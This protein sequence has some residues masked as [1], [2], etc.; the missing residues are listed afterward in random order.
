MTAVGRGI[1]SSDRLIGLSLDRLDVYMLEGH[2]R[3]AGELLWHDGQEWH[4]GLEGQDLAPAPLFLEPSR[5]PGR[6]AFRA[7]VTGGRTADGLELSARIDTLHGSL[8]EQPLG[9]RAVVDFDS[10]G[11][12]IP[13]LDLQWGPTVVHAAGSLA[14]PYSFSFEARTPD[15]GAAIPD[16][17]GSVEL[18]GRLT[19]TTA[20]PVVQVTMDMR[21]IELSTYR[22]ALLTGRLDLDLRSAGRIDLSLRGEQIELAK[23]AFRELRL[24]A[25]GDRTAHRISTYLDAG[26]L[27][28]ALEATG[29]LEGARESDRWRGTIRSLDLVSDPGGAWKLDSAAG[30]AIAP[31]E[32]TLDSLCL[33]S[34][35]SSFCSR[36]TWRREGGWEINSTLT[37]VP[38]VLLGSIFPP[39]WSLDGPLSGTID[40]SAAGDGSLSA[41]IN[42]IPGPGTI[43]YPVG[44]GANTVGYRA[45]TVRLDADAR[46]IR[47]ALSLNLIEQGGPAFGWLSARLELPGYSSLRQSIRPQ[48]VVGQ[49]DA[50]FESLELLA[51]LLTRFARA[52]GQL[53]TDLTIDGT[54]GQ[55][56]VLGEMRLIDAQA[57]VP[58]LGLRIEDVQLTAAGDGAGSI[59]FNGRARSGPGQLRIEGRSPVVP[60][61]ENPARIRIDGTNF[62]VSNT[63]A[64]EVLASP[65]IETVV[66]GE[67]ISVDGD[68]HI[69]RASIVL[70]QIPKSAV[71]VSDDVIFVDAGADLRRQRLISAR[72]RMVL[73]ED[74][75][76]GGFGLSTGLEG[77][78]L[79]TEEPGRP[80][81]GSGE[82]SMVE[83]TYKAYGQ[84]L[85]IE[86]GRFL[87][88]GGP[89]DNP[90][91]DLRASRVASDSVI[92]GLIVT[93]TLRRPTVTLF[94][95][96][97][98][99]ESEALSYLVLGRPLNETSTSEINTLTIAA[100]SLGL[101]GGNLL[102][103][104]IAARFGLAEARLEGGRSF[105]EATFVAGKYLSPRLYVIYGIGLFD[106][107]STFRVRYMLSSRWTLMGETG[108]ST[109]TDV[110]YRIE[111]GR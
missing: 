16:A 36:G 97:P 57:D 71:P 95:E 49:L 75:R 21:D 65:A 2:V 29:A 54:L 41:T 20:V 58:A 52:D 73:G 92:A 10:L 51:A 103:R 96:P 79:V 13:R 111:T 47:S 48:P 38:L 77:S 44:E 40:A 4:L 72:V 109:S 34:T 39:R 11:Y 88:G 50:R 108:E 110:L 59:T 106:H 55:P 104:K 26:D 7:G 61:P 5:W 70:S 64:A 94:S 56:R 85:T 105:Q 74:V 67:R 101:R 87:F 98:L 66:A 83:G 68:I 93:G 9:A 12:T 35:A 60:S 17:G 14:E 81:T 24:E 43:T 15:L 1:P 91:L 107:S 30:L 18:A 102:A 45:G 22:V 82:L 23:G 19:G 42:L 25:R 63:P 90:G 99:P 84:N 53:E 37:Q 76:F 69:P 28:I 86:R 33:M 8:R 80:T 46:G 6:I 27:T 78:I 89:I 100:R 3:G 32:I 62:Q 31:E